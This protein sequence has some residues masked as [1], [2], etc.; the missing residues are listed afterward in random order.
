VHGHRRDARARERRDVVEP[1]RLRLQR[2]EHARALRDPRLEELLLRDTPLELELHRLDRRALERAE[3]RLLAQQ[4]LRVGAVQ[5]HPPQRALPLLPPRDLGRLLTLAHRAAQRPPRAGRGLQRLHP[6]RLKLGLKFGLEALDL[7]RLGQ[8]R[9]Q[10]V[11][12]SLQAS[13]KHR[14][15]G[16]R[17]LLSTDYRLPTTEC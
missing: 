17:R 7:I 3:A 4:L 5:L 14:T 9:H 2:A 1:V 15:G 10:P 13:H 11:D 12:P 16:G 6:Y 8:F